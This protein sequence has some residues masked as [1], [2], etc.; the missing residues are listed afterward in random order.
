MREFLCIVLIVFFNGFAIV[1]QSSA[2]VQNKGQWTE[3]VIAQFDF[4]HSSLWFLED[5]VRVS[6]IDQQNAVRAVEAMHC[7]GELQGQVHGHVYDMI[8]GSTVHT[9]ADLLG[10]QQ[11]YLN[12]F[13][14]EDRSKWAS[15]VL[16]YQKLVM[17]EV[18]RGVDVSWE[19]ENG[20][21]KYTFYVGKNAEA[22]EVFVEY[23]G[24][25]SLKVSNDGKLIIG[26]KSFESIEQKPFAF[27]WYNNQKIEVECGF[28]VEGNRVFYDLGEFNRDYMLYIDPVIMASTFS[29]SSAEAFGHSATFDGP[30]NIYSAGRVFG[31]GY[32][33]DTGSFD[34]DFNGPLNPT[35]STY[36]NSYDIC[37][38]KYN[39]NGSGLI[40]S[41]YLGGSSQELPHSII[42]NNSNE[43]HVLGST[44]GSDF[45][46]TI[47]AYDTSHNGGQDIFITK[48]SADG[49]QLLGSTFLG[50]PGSDGVNNIIESYADDYRG[51]I[52]VDDSGSIYIASFSSSNAFPTTTNA[53]QSSNA[54]QQDAVVAK[55]DATLSNV[56]FST[57]LGGAGDDGAFG[58]K[59]AAQGGVYVGG[60]TGGQNFP[61]NST[62]N[63]VFPN[64]IGGNS[65]VFVLKLNAEASSILES[66]YYGTVNRE[67]AFFLEL[68]EL[69][70]VYLFGW[71]NGNISSSLGVYQGPTLG[72]FISKLSP[73]LDSVHWECGFGQFSPS[74]FLVDVCSH[75]Y[76]SGQ[77]SVDI[78]NPPT[79]GGPY[80]Q[81]DLTTFDTLNAI[82]NQG[83]GGFYLMTLSPDASTLES[84]FFYAPDSA[85]VDGGTSRFDKRGFVYQ[86]VCDCTGDFPTTPWAHQQNSQVSVPPNMPSNVC[87]NCV[88][89]IDFELPLVAAYASGVPTQG[90]APLEVEFTNQGSQGSNHFWDFGDG[91]TSNDSTPVHVF[92]SAGVYTVQY[93]VTDTFGCNAADTAYVVVSVIEESATIEI[94]TIQCSLTAVLSAADSSASSYL[95]S[96]GDTTQSTT[97]DSSGVYWLIAHYAQ[98]GLD[99][100]SVF[101]DWQKPPVFSLPSDT[102]VCEL[103]FELVGPDSLDNY[104]W[105][106][107]D[108]TQVIQI[109]Q[110]GIYS[111]SVSQGGCVYTDSIGIDVAYA[112]FNVSDTSLCEDELELSVQNTNGNIL[113]SNG[114]TVQST[115][116]N[117][118][119]TYWVTVS[120]GFC[121]STD[122]ISVNFTYLLEDVVL[123]SVICEPSFFSAK[124]IGGDSYLWSTGDTTSGITIDSSATIWLAVS[125]GNCSDTDTFNIVKQNLGVVQDDFTVCDSNSFVTPNASN[126]QAEY[127]WSTGDTTANITID[128]TGK[129]SV[130]IS[131]ENC[132]AIDT[133]QVTFGSSPEIDLGGDQFI[134]RGAEFT[135][136]LDSIQG[137]LI[138]NTGDTSK[139]LTIRQEGVYVAW[140]SDGVCTTSDTV[141]VSFSPINLDSFFMIPNV[142]TP[143]ED[144]KN[145]VLGLKIADPG[146]VTDYQLTVYNRWG[147]LMFD[148]EF[149]NHDWGGR[150]LAGVPVEEGVYFYLFK[151]ETK[152]TDFPVIE[153]KDH[154]TVL[155]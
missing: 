84:S 92:D 6:A 153:V 155:R 132:S 96:N 65:D 69:E 136:D 124:D 90:C 50:G 103:G 111:L 7:H 85:H 45:P 83:S 142:I 19:I 77:T 117:N 140:V 38:S 133:F 119:G 139:T 47:T 12:Y 72:S 123:D 113:W 56:M 75:I 102:G 18:H 107:G 57:Y 29:G 36:A 73:E 109:N 20:Y 128:E 147:V 15:E 13:L 122:T 101:V 154:V 37:I 22:D 53:I 30:G 40:Y 58:I 149:I 88:F 144:G 86:N 112:N 146:L 24:I 71:S 60:S 66:T 23:E 11:A 55:L 87:D 59:V 62:G 99:T 54:G 130:T 68:D 108:S 42:V 116:F 114:D 126:V 148:S 70:N 125:K 34:M 44:N 16:Q 106:S 93:A 17:H 63:G 28:R 46:T 131:S 134:C 120:N 145:D 39:P 31:S 52:V 78:F 5:R 89:K 26:L 137:Q 150:T 115:T 91:S 9:S 79:F 104:L 129:Y 21:P 82:N 61:V 80:Y 32:P 35:P 76:V 95:W 98:C 141:E 105:S 3:E 151:A 48:F 41:T 1:A 74:A 135:F 118:S 81:M 127:L 4:Q 152:C 67:H 94:D 51:E 10:E 27:Q 25:R 143:N 121:F 8:F 14:G 97:I 33:T 110:T 100:D 49:S 64:Y 43:L 2:F 138:W